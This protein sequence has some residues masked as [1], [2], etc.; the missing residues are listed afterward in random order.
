MAVPPTP[1]PLQPL[2][3]RA[4]RAPG[5]LLPYSTPRLS[6]C[7][8]LS[9]SRRPPPR[10]CLVFPFLGAPLPS[11]LAVC[12]QPSVCPPPPPSPTPTS[13]NRRLQPRLCRLSWTLASRMGAAAAVGTGLTGSSSSSSR[14]SGRHMARQAGLLGGGRGGQVHCQRPRPGSGHLFP[15]RPTL[16]SPL[17]FRTLLPLP[18]A[19]PTSPEAGP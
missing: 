5:F 2:T 7:I 6:C 14:T 4:K 10:T 18:C 13:N 16:C 9:R 12:P 19:R 3:F 15:P 1:F 8:S 17:L 11:S